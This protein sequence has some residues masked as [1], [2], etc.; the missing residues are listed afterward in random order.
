V[1]PHGHIPLYQ[2]LATPHVVDEH[3]QAALLAVDAPNQVAHLIGLQMVDPDGDA[4][5]APLVDEVGRLFD[6]LGTIV[7]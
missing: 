3:V 6:R 1:L 2:A 7:L 5:P 4:L